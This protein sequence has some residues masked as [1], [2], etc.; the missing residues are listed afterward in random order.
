MALRTRSFI[1]FFTGTYGGEEFR[2][3]EAVQTTGSFVSWQSFVEEMMDVRGYDD[4][5]ITNII[6]INPSDYEDWIN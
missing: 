2:G 3:N 1:V 5:L 6:E 4:C